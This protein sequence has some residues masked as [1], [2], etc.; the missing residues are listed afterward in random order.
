VINRGGP[1]GGGG[2]A[3]GGGSSGSTTTTTT[4]TASAPPRGQ[5]TNNFLTYV[6]A[7]NKI[8]IKYPS[9]WTKTDLVGNPS[10]PVMFNAPSAAT[11][12]P[13]GAATKTNF[14]ISITPGASNLDSFAH[15]QVNKLAQST[16]VKYTI[17]DTNSKI[18]TPPN[19]ISAFREVSYDAVKN[20]NIP[21]KGAGIFFV[22]GGTGYSLLYLAKQTDYTQNIPMVQQ[23]VNSFQV[24]GNGAGATSNGDAGVQN[25]AAAQ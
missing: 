9:T 2:G 20:D 25:V 23:M 12:T 14:V 21:L 1:S 11:T 5:T 18:L 17:T 10:I 24:G 13:G 19:G 7:A 15:Q 4:T 6:N 3:A 16:A 22:N 8:S